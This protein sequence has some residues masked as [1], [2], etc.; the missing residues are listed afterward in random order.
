MVTTMPTTHEKPK[1]TETNN[2]ADIDMEGSTSAD[3]E[4]KTP[5]T[6][7]STTT[8]TVTRNH[9]TPSPPP[10]T[11][12]PLV[13]EHREDK[14][15]DEL[16]LTHQIMEIMKQETLRHL[17]FAWEAQRDLAMLC[18]DDEIIDSDRDRDGNKN[19]RI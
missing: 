13:N 8:T 16:P 15:N 19:F 9:T 12:E 11:N 3:M 1:S 7:T 4:M 5:S 17:E 2:T 18:T 14:N 10:Q 6:S